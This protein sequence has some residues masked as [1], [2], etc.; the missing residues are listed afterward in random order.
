MAFNVEEDFKGQRV[1]GWI[2]GA[3]FAIVGVLMIIF[4]DKAVEIS[5]IVVGVFL[6]IFGIL[7]VVTAVRL[8]QML[9]VR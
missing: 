9:T 5:A 3:I 7:S 4:P 2:I 1:S 6:V 8:R